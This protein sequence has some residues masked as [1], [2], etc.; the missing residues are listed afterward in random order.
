MPP[1]LSLLPLAEAEAALE[2]ADDDAD[3]DDGFEL[4]LVSELLDDDDEDELDE[5]L[6]LLDSEELD[7][8][9]VELELDEELDAVLV[10]LSVELLL[11]AVADDEPEAAD[12]DA[13]LLESGA[14]VPS[15]PTEY[16]S[17]PPQFS[18][19]YAGHVVL[20]VLSS[21]RSELLGMLSEQ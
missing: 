18:L 17:V 13:E 8:L 7:A 9:D 3:D 11:E 10:E 1:P 15:Y 5:E 2:L 21:V 16:A 6:L 12:A 4:E 19:G 20:Q 14:V